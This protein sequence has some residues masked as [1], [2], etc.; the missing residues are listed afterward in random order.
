MTPPDAA[1]T[2]AAQP[3]EAAP[4]NA[5]LA[6]VEAR[7]RADLRESAAPLQPATADAAGASP[8][9]LRRV[10]ALVEESER[11]QQRELALRLAEAMREMNAQRQADLIRI[12]RNIGLVQNTTGR[13]MMRQRSEMLNYLTVRTASQRPQ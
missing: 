1:S 13:E 8:E 9:A 5:D 3:G 12:D 7:L 10:R 4:W 6:A 2:A 11:R